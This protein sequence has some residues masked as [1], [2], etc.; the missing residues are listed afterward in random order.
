MR[1]WLRL[2]LLGCCVG[3]STLAA[4]TPGDRGS[5]VMRVGADTVVIERFSHGGDTL[6][7]SIQVKGQPRQD[8][9]AVIGPDFGVRTLAL[10]VFASEMAGAAPTRHVVVTM[11]DDSA[12]VAVGGGVQRFATAHGALPLVNNSF[13]LMELFT[14][15][16]RASGGSTDIPAWTLSGGTT[17]RVGLRAVGA[18]SMA[19]TIGGSDE[20]LR[21]DAQGRILGGAIPSQRLEV[22]RGDDSPSAAAIGRLA[23][24]VIPAL[25]AGISERPVTVPGPVPLPGILTLPVGKGPFPGVVLVHGSGAG[26]RDE[27]LGGNKP[28]RDLAWGLAQRGIAVLR[29][30]KR[31]HVA[32]GWYLGRT[33]TVFD[34]TIDDA[35]SALALL[36]QQPEVDARRTVVAGHSLGGMLAPRIAVTDGK[37]AGVVIMEGATRI[38]LVDQME[39][40]YG[41]IRTVLATK[42]DSDQLDLQLNQLKP[43]F[44][45][46]RA[47]TPADSADRQLL[48]GATAKYYLDLNQYDP[49]VTA[50][51]VKAPILV[52]QGGRDYQVPPEQLD[53]WLKVVG[54]RAGLVV[55]RYPALNHLMIAGSGQPRPAEYATA[56]HVDAQLIADMA[57]WVR[58]LK[59]R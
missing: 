47:L 16:A 34:E 27:T 6:R 42:A 48:L 50:R 52:V 8:Y 26:D 4:Q 54:K 33:F 14:R 3:T 12:I 51:T 31:A 21:V 11:R 18:D 40:Q 1:Q 19:L 35:V 38:K 28:F 41:Y 57:A 13:A 25:P 23:A 56:G 37:L 29:Y 44:A 59:A 36:R 15:R 20:R 53:D 39:R 58:A 22:L 2:L 49:A 43:L 10:D 55:K 7:G 32:P 30:D 9:T 45:R 46:V 24:P 17:L 5:F